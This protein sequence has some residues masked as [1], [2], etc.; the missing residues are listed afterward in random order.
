MPAETAAS[1][2]VDEINRVKRLHERGSYD[3]ATVHRLL[4]SAALCS[5]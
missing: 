3:A 4:D 5:G 2:P 1:Y